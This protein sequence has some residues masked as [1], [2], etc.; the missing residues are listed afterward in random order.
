MSYKP[1]IGDLVSFRSSTPI[2]YMPGDAEKTHRRGN[3]TQIQGR[4]VLV[5]CSGEEIEVS[6]AKLEQCP[7]R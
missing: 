5:N 2:P 6:V 7:K 1:K 4:Y 3:I